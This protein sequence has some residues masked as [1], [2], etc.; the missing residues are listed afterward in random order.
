MNKLRKILLLVT[1]ALTALNA[2]PAL[3]LAVD[4]KTAITCGVNAAAGEDNCQA[5]PTNS[6]DVT[7]HR[8]INVLSVIIGVVAVIMII[9]GGFRYITS[10]G[11]P[12]A[13]KS[14]RQ[15]IIYAIIGLIVVA[16]AQAIAKFVLSEATKK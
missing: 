8:I 5:K 16:L 14:A 1:L 4:S 11:S 9:V 13:T 12:D 10:G 15:T 3:S 7:I 6:L 2:V